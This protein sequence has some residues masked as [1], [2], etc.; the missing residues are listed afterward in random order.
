MRPLLLAAAALACVATPAIADECDVTPAQRD[1]ARQSSWQ[2]FDQQG[3]APGTFRDLSGKRCYHAALTAYRDWLEN[4]AGFQDERQRA[5]GTFHIAQLLAFLDE[6]DTAIEFFARATWRDAQT[7]PAAVAW[8]LY[9]DGVLAF[10][11][12][13]RNAMTT[14]IAALQ[15]LDGA[16]AGQWKDRLTGLR[17]C[18]RKDYREAMSARC[19]AS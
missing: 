7:N 9:V 5:I 15:D 2:I 18:L 6:T 11:A 19:Q 10:F 4:G 13:D 16:T 8:N 14:S 3:G 1:A 12:S 17:R